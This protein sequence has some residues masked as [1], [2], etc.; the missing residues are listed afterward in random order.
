[1]GVV[2]STH[3]RLKK[4]EPVRRLALAHI[5]RSKTDDGLFVAVRPSFVAVSAA[6]MEGQS[7]PL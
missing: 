4:R 7:V 1:M 5:A 2:P 3:E 6:L